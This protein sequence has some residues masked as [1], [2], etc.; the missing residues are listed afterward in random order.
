MIMIMM[1]WFM[2]NDYDNNLNQYIF[3]NNFL[4]I[5]YN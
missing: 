1:I 2:I 3:Q 4:L 5:L